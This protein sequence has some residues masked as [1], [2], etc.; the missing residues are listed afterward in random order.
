M[1]DVK[2]T[3]AQQEVIDNR[4]S[5]LLV[6]AAAGSGKTAVLVEHIIQLILDEENPI[7]IDRLMVVTFT[8]AAAGEMR[9]RIMLAIENALKKN[10]NNRHL[11]K[12]MSYIHNAKITTLHSFCLN[13]IR[14]YFNILD[15]AP[16]F[17][18][19]DTGE[20][21]L[22]QSD[23]LNEVIE[24]FYQS[25]S[26]DFHEFIE[27]ASPA[28]KDKN[29]EELVL[30]FYNMAMST[31]QPEKFI[32]DS[33]EI[34]DVTE[35]SLKKS[36]H[37]KILSDYLNS[38]LDECMDL[39]NRALEII[40]S[41]N[42]PIL[43]E[44][45]LKS[46]KSQLEFII[47]QKD[48][49]EKCSQIMKITYERLSSKKDGC[50]EDK[51]NEVKKIRDQ[52]KNQIKK[53]QGLFED[54]DKET[55]F[56][57]INNLKNASNAFAELTIAFMK[58]YAAKKKEK[59]IVDFNDFEHFALEILTEEKDGKL[60][61]SKIADEIAGTID[62]VI[63]DE[64]QDINEV[65][66]TILRCL[67]AERFGKPDLF[68]VGDVKQSIY[69]FR[70]ADPAIFV[71]KYNRYS[72][73][74]KV[75][76]K[77]ILEKNFRSRPEVLDSVNHIF[78]KIMYREF[79]DIE[80]DDENALYQG[81]TFEEVADKQNAKTEILIATPPEEIVKD[82]DENGEFQGMNKKEIEC[83][84]V[85]TKIRELTD[86][87]NGYLV[88][89]K[90]T[91]KLRVAKYSD[92]LILYRSVKNNA[93]IM[94]EQLAY[95]GIPAY[96]ECQ[97]GYFDTIEVNDV[98]SYL[99]I[100][101]NPMQ[102][103]PFAATMKSFFGGFKNYELA[104]IRSGKIDR[105]QK[106]SLYENVLEYSNED[107]EL[108]KK[109]AAFL[110]KLEGYR[111]M[112]EYMSIYELLCKIIDETGYEQYV[113][114]MP[115][116][117]R[118]IANIQ[119]L[120]EKAI[121]Y[122]K[123]SYK[124]LFNFVRYIEKIRKYD[125]DSGEASTVSENENVVTIMSI[126]KSKGLEY[127]IVFICNAN[128][129]INEMD[130][131]KSVFIH[132]KLGVGMEY[133]DSYTRVKTST[134]Y[135]NA[136][137]IL[138]NMEIRQEE[139]RILYV[140]MT[141][142][143]EK[144]FITSAGVTDSKKEVYERVDTDIKKKVGKA[145]LAGAS[146]LLDDICMACGMGCECIDVKMIPFEEIVKN[147]ISVEIKDKH[148]EMVLRNWDLNVVIDEEIREK[149]KTA[150]EYIYPFENAVNHNAKVS[151]SDLKHK[152]IEEL[153]A[154]NDS[155]NPFEINEVQEYIPEFIKA[156]NDLSETD[157]QASSENGKM[158][159]SGAERGTA[160]HRILELLDYS[161]TPNYENVSNMIDSFVEQGLIER[162][163]AKAVMIKDIVK[164]ATSQLG[165][166]MKSAFDKNKLYR[167]AQFVMGVDGRSLG[168]EIKDIVLVQGIVDAYFY[169]DDEIVIVDY[170]TDR[171]GNEKEL[172]D[173]YREQLRQYKIALEGITGKNVKEM[174]LYSVC[175]SK[176]V[177]LDVN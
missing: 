85:A 100:I 15:I 157:E 132:K 176:E 68:M 105:E 18:I 17:R 14:E 136:I 36:K 174:I 131:K 75:N 90:K 49:Y 141:R 102:D 113:S 106:K 1:S 169:E 41:D 104:I 13:L 121:Q 27:Y 16:G 23:V 30:K 74:D 128:G 59:N 165:K 114:A 111:D 25:E 76:R 172:A 78:R 164:F 52:I 20:L 88:T 32:R 137:K 5:N 54:A 99:N 98:L 156:D 11:Q 124:G 135:K 146:S 115:S 158:H 48:Y 79:G 142:A 73:N 148:D 43:Y 80:Y 31:P 61:P 149:C 160:Y 44:N 103:I 12:Q 117:E 45:A 55:D 67:S 9:E 161:V 138:C 63:V 69:G 81:R 159:I 151:V 40:Y 42:G 126:H 28:G 2:Y 84:M 127:P 60:V 125:I 163:M 29:V 108:G 57:T 7:D 64:Y 96:Y 134:V 139:M 129:K 119:M 143:K 101:D 112:A 145:Y 77:I 46:D 118:R 6:S 97:T 87:N 155:V 107:N 33:V 4:A 51:K 133:V 72:A 70:M 120:M 91:G 173:R 177:I 65:Q 50:D 62:E 162:D 166:R 116:G 123:T 86:V 144:L 153:E 3:Q 24:E 140:A 82:E 94:E 92:I 170:K 167:E 38:M 47:S 35:E 95:E 89:D 66:E 150:M 154:E 171:V 109:A 39:C 37:I 83:R 130:L 21:S 26:S 147:A 10:S 175:L 53:I 34:Y 93:E 58:R 19:G 122:E 71:D 152:K 8:N 56:E 22:M 168:E 110:D